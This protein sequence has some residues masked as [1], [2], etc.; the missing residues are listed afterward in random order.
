MVASSTATPPKSTKPKKP[1]KICNVSIDGND[2]LTIELSKPA[3]LSFSK[4][5]RY[6][7]ALLK[8][9]PT[10]AAQAKGIRDGIDRL[11]KDIAGVLP[12]KTDGLDV[13]LELPEEP[14]A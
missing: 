8:A 7:D 9:A 11:L 5:R 14:L 4:T 3:L 6:C 1:P 12:P 13:D 2:K 10:V